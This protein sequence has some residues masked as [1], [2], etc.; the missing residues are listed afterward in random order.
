MIEYSHIFPPHIFIASDNKP[1]LIPMWRQLP[2]GTKL[3]DIK[4]TN[5]YSKNPNEILGTVIGS[6]GDKY[7]ITRLSSG[8]VICSCPGNTYKGKCKHT[9]NY[10]TNINSKENTI[11]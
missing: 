2:I 11:K 10:E 8:Q 5:P 4:W 3:E 1:Y 6:K 7:T 9:K